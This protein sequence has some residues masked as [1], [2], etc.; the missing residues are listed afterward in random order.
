MQGREF[1]G[2]PIAAARAAAIGIGAVRRREA[3]RFALAVTGLLM[4]AVTMGG[5]R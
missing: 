4:V 5:E 1:A 3:V 2:P